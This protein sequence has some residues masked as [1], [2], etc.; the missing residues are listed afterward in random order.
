MK[1][2][3]KIGLLILV[4]AFVLSF[5][6]FAQN[7]E[8]PAQ[9]ALSDEPYVFPVRPGTSEWNEMEPLERRE[10]CYV[11]PE[12]AAGMTTRA[13]LE[14]ILNYPYRGEL[15]A[16]GTSEKGVTVVARRFSVMAEFLSRQD[17]PSMLNAFGTLAYSN[18]NA[19]RTHDEVIKAGCLTQIANY[20]EAQQT[21][22]IGIE[23]YYTDTTVRTPNG[24][25]VDAYRNCTWNDH[26]T[27]VQ[28]AADDMEE[29]L[30][31]FPSGREI[32]PPAPKY[33]CHSYAWYSTASTNPI[34]IDDPSAYVEDGSYVH[35][36]PEKNARVT[37]RTRGSSTILVS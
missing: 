27:T 14:T 22:D 16:F 2:F 35:A 12:T 18:L 30:T 7:T 9:P 3:K 33:N 1:Q 20:L 13:L 4:F 17:G 15:F 23:P 10:A 8:G 26:R 31:E 32:R 29:L 19:Q 21:G 11:S 28:D 5:S 34:W 24:T 6:A 36:I 37:Y 25:F